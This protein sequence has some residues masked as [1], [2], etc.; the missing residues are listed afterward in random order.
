M[1]Q[2]HVRVPGGGNTYIKASIASLNTLVGEQGGGGLEL[3]FLAN[4]VDQPGSTLATEEEIQPIGKAYP[5]EIATAYGMKAG[6]LTLTVWPTWGYDGWVSA[7]AKVVGGKLAYAQGVWGNG[8]Y[9]SNNGGGSF[10]VDLF[11]VFDAQRKNSDYMTI[12][13]VELG[14]NGATARIK[15]YQNCVITNIDAGETI[16]NDSMPRDIQTKIT[17]KYTHVY[18]NN[19]ATA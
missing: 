11:E 4:V 15:E 2:T 13:K 7:F 16:R 19:I 12:K 9:T 18:V 17:I 8:S 5:V 1:P 6:T 14:A 3:E 10:P